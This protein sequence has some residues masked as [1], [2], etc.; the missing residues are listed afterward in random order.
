MSNEVILSVEHLMMHFGGIKALSDVSLKVRRN[1]IFALIGPNGAG[2]T[3][4][5][6]CLTGFY[7]ATGG[8]IELHTR[9]RTTDVIR[10]LG[11]P[12][13]ATDFISP[14]SFLSRVY[15]KM[16][17]GT[18][19]VNR[20]GLARTFQNIRLFKEMSVVENLLVA[21]HMWV[22]RSLISGIL[23]TKGYRKAEEDALDT[24]FYW[25]EV[26]DLV[27]CANRLAGELSYGQ[28]RRLEI[29]RAMCTR[30][31]VICLDEPAA[32]LNPQ[33]TEALSGMIR[34]LRDEHDMTIVLIEHDMGMVM[35]IS[36]DIVV[37]DHGNV[38]AMG[39]PE[40]IRNDPKVIAAYLGA[41]EEELV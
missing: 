28:Q 6:N 38:I 7:K 3:T 27:D 5:F 34:L 40:Q 29:A 35:G 19:L 23:N 36:D 31:Q 21:Q 39:G 15:Y 8:R 33:E 1:S 37:L 22:N 13:K 18:H 20:A 26:V 9:D 10:L 30:P 16:F 11:E 41:D 2:K 17:G 24:A 4:V 14:K 12:F 32:G 25:L